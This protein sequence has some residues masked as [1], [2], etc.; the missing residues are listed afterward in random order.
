M[1][2]SY[3]NVS[4]TVGGRAYVATSLTINNSVAYSPFNRLGE[5][6]IWRANAPVAS[7]LSLSAFLTEGNDFTAFITDKLKTTKYDIGGKDA[8]L[9]SLSIQG[10]AQSPVTLDLQFNG[11]E[12]FGV[13]T[14]S[15]S[16]TSATVALGILTAIGGMPSSANYTFSYTLTKN[17]GQF[18]TRGGSAQTFYLT[19]GEEKLTIEGEGTTA[20]TSPCPAQK[21]LS[22]SFKKCGA[23][24][25]GEISVEDGNVTEYSSSVE[26]GNIVKNT[27][28]VVKTF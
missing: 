2:V 17:Y 15:P 22:L 23:A 14:T 26:A 16:T 6:G 11:P 5:R 3:K 18:L 21:T 9:T 13:T 7:S 1:A 20:L 12:A 25:A 27:I 24:G 19:G 4:A 8:Y 10:D 28:T